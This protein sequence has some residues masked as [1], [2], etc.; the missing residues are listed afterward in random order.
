MHRCEVGAGD[1]AAPGPIKTRASATTASVAET[2]TTTSVMIGSG[3]EAAGAA[4]TT[5]AT[6]TV[7]VQSLQTSI[8]TGIDVRL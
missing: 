3:W 2:T 1:F 5:A 4:A 8:V 6:S 7:Q